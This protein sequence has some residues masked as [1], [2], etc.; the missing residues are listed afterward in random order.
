MVKT[1]IEA[2]RRRRSAGPLLLLASA[3]LFLVGAVSFN[4]AGKAE[5]AKLG[6]GCAVAAVAVII[7]F[8]S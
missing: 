5:L 1:F 2:I 3:A 4:G 7:A 8:F 6:V